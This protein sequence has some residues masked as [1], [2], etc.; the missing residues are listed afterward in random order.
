MGQI[1]IIYWGKYNSVMNGKSNSTPNGQRGRVTGC[2]RAC[3]ESC[4][5]R[6]GARGMWKPSAWPASTG[7]LE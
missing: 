3:G 4:E 5:V 6:P 2:K 1:L 7:L